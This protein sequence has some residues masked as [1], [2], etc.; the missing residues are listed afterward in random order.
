MQVVFDIGGT[1]VRAAAVE[2]PGRIRPLGQV[3]T[4]REDFGAFAA[5]LGGLMPEGTRGIALSIAGVVDPDGGR[6]KVANIACI[7][8]RPLGMREPWDERSASTSG[9]RTR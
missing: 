2:A 5:A 6:A 4:P 7:D 8:G 3:P 1:S 9:R